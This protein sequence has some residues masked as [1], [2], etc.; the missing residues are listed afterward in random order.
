M[1]WVREAS[2][3]GETF[4]RTTHH[5]FVSRYGSYLYRDAFAEVLGSG[6]V[7]TLP[8]RCQETPRVIK[9]PEDGM[10]I[11][12]PATSDT[13]SCNIAAAQNDI[14]A[15][16]SSCICNSATAHLA[17]CILNDYWEKESIHRPA[18]LRNFSLSK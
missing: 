16:R 17:V 10:L 3:R 8:K 12:L 5:Q 1:G 14:P 15:E 7:G 2:N 9:F 18:P 4:Q 13:S 11:H 6:V